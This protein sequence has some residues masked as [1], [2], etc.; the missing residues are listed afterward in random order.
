M[1]YFIGECEVKCGTLF[2]YT[3]LKKGDKNILFLVVIAF[4]RFTRF[5]VFFLQ[6]KKNT[7]G[8]GAAWCKFFM[9]H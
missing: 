8:G 3:Y 9:V 4:Y 5:N 7:D 2:L 1:Q 6:K